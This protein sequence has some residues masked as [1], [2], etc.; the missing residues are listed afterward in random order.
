MF[1]VD[2]NNDADRDV[3]AGSTDDVA[4]GSTDSVT[5]VKR[6]V[7]KTDETSFFCDVRRKL[8]MPTLSMTS[9]FGWAEPVSRKVGLLLLFSRV[10]LMVVTDTLSYSFLIV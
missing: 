4:T 1:Y 3:N 6:R 10:V 8:S 7:D 2:L 5:N 9:R